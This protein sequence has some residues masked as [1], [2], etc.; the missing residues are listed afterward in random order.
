[1]HYNH[2]HNTRSKDKTQLRIMQFNKKTDQ[3]NS[4]YIS[5]KIY[6]FREKANTAPNATCFKKLVT[7]SKR[8]HS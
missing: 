1:M 8:N 3:R 2:E 6:N 4:L 7:T 5:P